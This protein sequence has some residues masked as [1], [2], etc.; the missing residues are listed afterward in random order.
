MTD[1]RNSEHYADPTAAKAIARCTPRSYTITIPGR[2]PDLNDM[3]AQA[4]RGRGRY[5]PY[6]SEK[7]ANT[8]LVAWA[9]QTAHVPRLGRVRLKITW[10]EPD[11]RRDPDNISAAQKYI[12]DGL[13]MAGVIKDD[14]Q[15][16]MAGISH[17]WGVDKRNPR[18]VVEIEEV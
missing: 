13:V 10:I 17:A 12:C 16:Y 9:C 11:A 1:N 14:G 3:I 6:A 2:F 7:A 8:G 15:R 18:V 4:K 5:Q